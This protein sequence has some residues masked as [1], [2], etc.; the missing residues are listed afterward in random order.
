MLHRLLLLSSLSGGIFIEVRT[1]IAKTNVSSETLIIGLPI[2]TSVIMFS[3]MNVMDIEIAGI[4]GG[5]QVIKAL[6]L[7]G[8]GPLH[9][10]HHPLGILRD[11]GVWAL[12]KHLQIGFQLGPRVTHPSLCRS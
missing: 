6:M 5:V 12:V 10:S 3:V 4:K 9:H 7:Q 2:K 8:E 11:K 1:S